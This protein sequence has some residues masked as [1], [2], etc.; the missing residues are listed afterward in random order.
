MYIYIYIIL[1]IY[2]LLDLGLQL[3]RRTSYPLIQ[4]NHIYSSSCKLGKLM[5]YMSLKYFG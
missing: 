2:F 5:I 3:T 4:I 1:F